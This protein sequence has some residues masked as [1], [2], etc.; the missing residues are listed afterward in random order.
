MFENRSDAGRKLARALE[1]WKGTPEAIILA[2]PMGGIP[3]AEAAAADLGL[4]VEPF[5]CV[6][7]RHS[8]DPRL[9]L[10][11]L[12]ETGV[13]YFNPVPSAERLKGQALEREL[14]RAR[15]EI[16]ERKRLLHG[17]R[18]LPDLQGRV[19]LLIDDGIITGATMF[20]SARALRQLGPA[21]LVIAVPAAAR[22]AAEALYHEADRFIAL[23]TLEEFA[24][25]KSHYRDWLRLP[26]E[27]ALASLC[28]CPAGTPVAGR[29]TDLRRRLSS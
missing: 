6:K 22:V 14:A 1:R 3:V 8:T 27:A 25:L 7:L 10:G 5:V 4:P 16:A 9:A 2:V 13:A 26:P 21:R 12:T 17:P 28:R 18:G 15:A 11:A 29:R 23:E 20:A 24:T 19:V